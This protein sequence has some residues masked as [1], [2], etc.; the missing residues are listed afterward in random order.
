MPLCD[1]ID[2][3]TNP[4]ENRIAPL[5]DKIR[6]ILTQLLIL[7]DRSSA[8][9]MIANFGASLDLDLS[10]VSPSI[11]PRIR[12]GA[13][14]DIAGDKKIEKKITTDGRWRPPR[15]IS[16]PS[17]SIGGDRGRGHREQSAMSR[18]K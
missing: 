10:K 16:K 3:E 11:N 4:L 1:D 6:R 5:Y 13:I 15:E 2:A 12:V 7:L 14:P 17:R 9:L 18:S 8:K